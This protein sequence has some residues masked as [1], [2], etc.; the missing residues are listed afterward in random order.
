VNVG[1][2]SDQN[3]WEIRDKRLSHRQRRRAQ[4]TA[5]LLELKPHD[6][7][8]DVGCGESFVASYLTDCGFIVGV[9]LNLDA[10][11]FG[12]GKVN[13]ANVSFVLCTLTNL[14]FKERVF[15]KVAILEVLEHLPRISQKLLANE[16][17][18]VVRNRGTLVISVPYKERIE[19]TRCIHC[20]KRTPLWGHLHT[21][22]KKDVTALLPSHYI[23]LTTLTLPNV[24]FISLSGLF[25]HLHLKI[26][27]LLNNLLGKLH[28]GYWLLLKYRKRIN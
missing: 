15:D 9:D 8:L 21:M 27:L 20:G 6:I 11:Q 17:D 25:S 5:L 24:G 1:S 23:L 3:I 19:Y 28:K 16:V 14:P 12:K 7:L 18:R 13:K 2:M 4:T 22:D 10:L 26:W